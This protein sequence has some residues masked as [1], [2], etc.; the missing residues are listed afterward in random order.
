MAIDSANTVHV[1]WWDETPGNYEI[2]YKRSTDG[3]TTWSASQRLT[4]TP[5]NSSMPA[6]AI[7][8]SDTIHIVWYDETPND[9]EIY[10]KRSE[11]GGTTWTASQRLT[12][13]AGFS[14]SP[15]MTIDSGDTIHIVWADFSP[16][17][18]EI[19]YKRSEDGG[20]SWSVAQRLTWTAD[21]S[22]DPAAAMDSGNAVHV[23]WED[24][25]P[26]NHEV[27]YKWSAGGG[28]WTAARRLTWTADDSD[29]PTIAIDSSDTIHVVW[30]DLSPGNR[31]IYYRRS[32]DGGTTWSASQRL[33][34]NAGTSSIP[35]MAIASDDTIHVCWLDYSFPSS[36][37]CYKTSAD[38][39]AT[40]GSLQRLTWT[41]SWSE[42][43]AIAIDSVGV[44]HIVWG[45]F[46]P[47]NYEIYYKKS[48]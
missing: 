18:Y 10:Y 16:G 2:Y 41:D 37:I 21:D 45:D 39:G 31:E 36:E 3:G 30:N 33:T 29:D 17:N 25:T 40:W 5:G 42:Y 24:N 1:V 32:P 6:M 35:S 19:Y 14:T 46:T 34:W 28:A 13:T 48:N 9:R 44:V 15:G 23:I 20:S 12:W 4:W 11:D 22:A 47:G 7:D 27:Y 43:P 26:G 8:S 38:G